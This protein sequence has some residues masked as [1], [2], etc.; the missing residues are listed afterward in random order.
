[1]KKKP[2][3]S[4]VVLSS[5]GHWDGWFHTRQQLCPFSLKDSEAG[6]R[7]EERQ[8]GQTLLRKYS[9]RLPL[10]DIVFP[11]VG[12]IY[13]FMHIHEKIIIKE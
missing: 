12:L 5:Q 10:P 8:R 4:P 11:D 13:S 3:T 9:R 7:G 1:M 6:G 2:I